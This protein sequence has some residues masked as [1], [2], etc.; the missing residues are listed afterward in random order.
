M[1]KSVKMGKS[2][3]RCCNSVSR[4]SW[5]GA[6]A[7]GKGV[8]WLSKRRANAN[9]KRGKSTQSENE[10]APSLSQFSYDFHVVVA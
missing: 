9:D 1:Q 7:V 3:N 6:I 10:E 8:A 2:E 5:N 4:L